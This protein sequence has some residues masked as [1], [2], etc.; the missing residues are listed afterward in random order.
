M[1]SLRGDFRPGEF[2]SDVRLLKAV[3][4]SDCKRPQHTLRVELTVGEV[5]ICASLIRF[6]IE[7]GV[8]FDGLKESTGL[9]KSQP[10]KGRDHYSADRDRTHQDGLDFR[11]QIKEEHIAEW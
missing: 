11:E 9:K 2:E 6:W 3:I 8:E 4:E 5:T 7:S 10:T 1:P